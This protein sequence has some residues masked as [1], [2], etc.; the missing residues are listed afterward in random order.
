MQKEN[1][2]N[3]KLAMSVTNDLVS[4][5]RVHKI[6]TELSKMGFNITLIGR[7]L[8]NSDAIKRDYETIRFKLLFNKKAWFYMEYNLRLFLFL[9]FRKFDVIVANDLDTLLASYI[10]SKLKGNTLVYDSHEY[11]TEVPELLE[12]PKIR[13][14]WLKIEKYIFPKLK[15][16]YTVNSSIAQIY[17]EKYKVDVKVVRNMAPSLKN[18]TIDQTL[19]LKIKGHKNMLILQGAGINIDRGAEELIEAM[20]LIDNAILYII[21]SGDIFETL[22][23]M[24]L[25]KHLQNKIKIIDKLPYDQL[26]EYTKIAD[27]GLS[28]D[29]GTNPNYEN[30]LP[31][32]V[33]DYIQAQTPLLVSNRKHVA[34][35]VN[36]YKIGYVIDEVSPI[37][38][39]E[40]ISKL[41]LDSELYAD[42]L[43]NLTHASEKLSWENETKSLNSI[44]LPILGLK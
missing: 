9:L 43:N 44:Y 6:A 35:L 24:V 27:I 33:F 13:N 41:L 15:H 12:R 21:G 11:Y 7:K 18:K 2:K 28:L 10:V 23:S 37:K 40:G 3:K 36:E 17:K 22:K 19:S 4:D 42:C 1:L 32:K 31:N 38:I 20:D 8:R 39:S 25:E 16:V 30:S 14:I 26:M 34:G 5:Q 29:K